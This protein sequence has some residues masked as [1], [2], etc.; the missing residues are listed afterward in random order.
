[1]RPL[2]IKIAIH[3]PDLVSAICLQAEK[4]GERA[5]YGWWVRQ[6]LRKNLNVKCS[7]SR[8]GNH[9]SNKSTKEVNKQ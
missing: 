9:H 2:S 8:L 4:D 3:K 6:Y 7:A 1:M 5:D